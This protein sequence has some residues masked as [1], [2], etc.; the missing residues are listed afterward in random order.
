M[1][2]TTTVKWQTGCSAHFRAQCEASFTAWINLHPTHNVQV[3]GRNNWTQTA[4]TFDEALVLNGLHGTTSQWDHNEVEH[5]TVRLST[6][7]LRAANSWYT[8]HWRPGG[9]SV[10]LQQPDDEASNI[11]RRDRAKA[12][13]QRR[14]ERKQAKKEQQKDEDKKD[15][16]GNTGGTPVSTRSGR[17]N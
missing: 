7:T 3:G 10:V 9:G 8:L 2:R 6:P 1:S 16:D 5:V 17:V 4:I 13:K 15:K 14:R 12:K 11:T